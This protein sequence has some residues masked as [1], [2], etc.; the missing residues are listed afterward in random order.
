[1]TM[2][3]Y[4]LTDADMAEAF[5]RMARRELCYIPQRRDVQIPGGRAVYPN[6]LLWGHPNAYEVVE[7]VTPNGSA[8][9]GREREH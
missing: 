5:K 2:R 6:C 1:M 7:T 8:Y 4:P 3:E 9:F